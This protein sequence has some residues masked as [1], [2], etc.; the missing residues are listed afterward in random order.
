MAL[1]AI[2]KDYCFY[3]LKERTRMLWWPQTE[4]KSERLYKIRQILIFI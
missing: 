1:Y 4:T 3:A 2:D